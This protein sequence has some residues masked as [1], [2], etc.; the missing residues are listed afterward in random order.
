MTGRY[1]NRADDPVRPLRDRMEEWIAGGPRRPEGG[2]S[3]AHEAG[4]RS[5]FIDHGRPFRFD[6]WLF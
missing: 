2:R 4:S 5:R 1:V 6:H 3:C